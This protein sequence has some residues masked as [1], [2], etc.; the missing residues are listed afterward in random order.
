MKLLWSLLLPFFLFGQAAKQEKPQTTQKLD[1]KIL[2]VNTATQSI[3]VQVG[4]FSQEFVFTPKTK[5]T[6]GG[7]EINFRDLKAN[8]SITIVFESA[9]YQNELTSLVVTKPIVKNPQP[10][11]KEKIAINGSIT[12]LE[13]FSRMLVINASTRSYQLKVSTSAQITLKGKKGTFSDL[14]R[15]QTVKIEGVKIGD[16]IDP[17]TIHIQ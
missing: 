2:F 14:Q 12:M 16:Q 10:V 13:P 11:Q 8:Q 15:G 6:S 4:D 1:G 3:M 7:K 9:N 5:M 17:I